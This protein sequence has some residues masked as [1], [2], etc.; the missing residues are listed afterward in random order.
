VRA[1]LSVGACTASE[2][3]A[4][5]I[6]RLRAAGNDALQSHRV[7]TYTLCTPHTTMTSCIDYLFVTGTMRGTMQFYYK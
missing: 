7:C 5:A 3:I 6:C 1:Q 4:T 2:A